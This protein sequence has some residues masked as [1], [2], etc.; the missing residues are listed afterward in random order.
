MLVPVT[1][2]LELTVEKIRLSRPYRGM[3]Y[4]MVKGQ[5]GF[6]NKGSAAVQVI[7][8]FISRIPHDAAGSRRSNSAAS[9]GHQLPRPRQHPRRQPQRRDRPLRP[10]RAKSER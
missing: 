8:L 2:S 10:N 7:E 6:T 9:C 5:P 4:Y 3:A 1:G